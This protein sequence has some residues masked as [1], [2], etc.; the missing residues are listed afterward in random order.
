MD[1]ATQAQRI[2]RLLDGRIISDEKFT[3]NDK[4]IRKRKDIGD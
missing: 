1:V 3:H 4:V 2:I